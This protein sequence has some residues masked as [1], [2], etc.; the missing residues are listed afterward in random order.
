MGLLFLKNCLIDVRQRQSRWW[1][2]PPL[3]G[4]LAL[5]GLPLTLGFMMGATLVRG[6]AER[7]HLGWGGA[8]FFGNLFLVPALA[9]WLRT[10]P[11]PLLSHEGGSREE[12]EGGA[13]RWLA[14]PCGIG[15]AMPML[16][17]IIAGLVP[18]LIIGTTDFDGSA[19]LLVP[20]L[21]RLLA[22]PGLMGWLLW[23]ISIAA[24]GLLAWQDEGLRFRIEPLFGA[25]HDLLRLEWLYEVTVGALERGLSV[26]RGIDEVVGGAGALLWSLLIFFLLVLILGS[27]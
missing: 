6:I 7:G 4:A 8:F 15:L 21:G 22:M 25:I 2:I 3:V 9:R 18:S 11:S 17:L 24:G 19:P 23:T 27:M 16:L 14:V 20:S 12:G 26:L 1:R 5:L 10:W 13:Y